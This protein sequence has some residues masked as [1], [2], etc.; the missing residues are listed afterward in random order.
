[1]EHDTYNYALMTHDEYIGTD[2][3]NYFNQ[4]GIDELFFVSSLEEFYFKINILLD[5]N[6]NKNEEEIIRSLLNLFKNLDNG[7]YLE[8]ISKYPSLDRY[9]FTFNKGL[10]QDIFLDMGEHIL[11]KVNK[12]VDGKTIREGIKVYY[13]QVLGLE[14]E[15]LEQKV[16]EVMEFN[17]KKQAVKFPVRY[18][19]DK[20][21]NKVVILNG[22]NKFDLEESENLEM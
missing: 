17:K 2:R 16:N 22:K 6:K 12:Q 15:E 14:G 10:I 20:D 13:Q 9:S 3:Y 5:K 18:K 21:E 4:W 8:L 7:F 11:T 19:I 1:M